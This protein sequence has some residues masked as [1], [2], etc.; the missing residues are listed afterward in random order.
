MEIPTH[1]SLIKE[2]T[3]NFTKAE[4]FGKEWEYNPFETRGDASDYIHISEDRNY[5]Y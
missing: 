5:V 1:K 2:I 4:I 3:D